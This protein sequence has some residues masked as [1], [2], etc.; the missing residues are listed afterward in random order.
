[1]DIVKVGQIRRGRVWLVE[2]QQQQVGRQRGRTAQAEK[3]ETTVS[4]IYRPK[5]DKA[6]THTYTQIRARTDR[7]TYTH[8]QKL[9]IAL[10]K[11]YQMAAR[12]GT[13]VPHASTSPPA[14][15]LYAALLPL[16]SPSPSPPPIGD[17]T[18]ACPSNVWKATD[19]TDACG[20][21]LDPCCI[22]MCR[23]SQPRSSS[24]RPRHSKQDIA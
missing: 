11:L 7:C 13:A 8:T 3:C 22:C 5:Q 10:C 1:M 4:N 21:L 12:L 2:R 19:Q 6:R 16:L 14:P 15:S 23:F 18:G 24:A 9:T 17:E 20:R